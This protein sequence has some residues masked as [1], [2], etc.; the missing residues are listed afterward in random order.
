MPFAVIHH[1]PGGTKENYDARRSRPFTPALGSSR[2]ARPSTRPVRW[3]K[4]GWTIFAVAG[5]G[6]ESW[7]AFRDGDVDPPGCSRAS[8]V[9]FRRHRRRPRSISSPSCRNRRGRADQDRPGREDTVTTRNAEQRRGVTHVRK[10]QDLSCARR[11]R[12]REKR[13]ILPNKVG[14]RL[15][16]ETI[17]NHLVFECGDGTTLLVY[18]RP[19]GNRA[20]HTQVRFWSNDIEKDVANSSIVVSCSRSTTRAFKTVDHVVTTAGIG[21]SAWFKDPDGNTIAVYHPS[22]P[23]VE[24]MGLEP[25]AG[26]G[27]RL[28]RRETQTTTAATIGL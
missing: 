25:S 24:S 2:R 28:P 13:S 19:N 27:A 8:R 10:Q 18:G 21:R 9:A 6:R 11:D 14:L 12:S 7:E 20:D 16:P 3:K 5:F 23:P 17:K 1:F 15:S 22:S 4:A 26:H